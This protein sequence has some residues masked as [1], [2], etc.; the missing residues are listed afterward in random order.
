VGTVPLLPPGAAWRYLDNGSDQG[1]NWLATGFD[2]TGWASGNAQFGY[3]EGDEATIINSGPTASRFITTYF[4]RPFVVADPSTLTGLVARLLRDD[5]AV[6]HL[7]GVELFRSNMPTGAV[8]YLTVAPQAVGG[9]D[10]TT[11]FVTQL[12]NPA[13][14]PGTNVLAVEIHQQASS[15]S[16]VSFDLEL[17]GLTRVGPPR[18]QI[19]SAG[20]S[21]LL[22]WP[23]SATGSRL[24]FGPSPAGAWQYMPGEPADD[25]TWKTMTVPPQPGAQFF[26]LAP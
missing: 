4:R 22:R 13:L 14:R 9:A 1:T 12:A 8:N 10:E 11:F 21:V 3:G 25:G 7:N 17:I 19:L 16:D 24:Q 15:S 5:G 20:P 23:S 6:V 2:D 18:V 26:R